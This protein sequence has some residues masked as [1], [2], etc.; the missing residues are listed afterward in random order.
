M[1]YSLKEHRISC[2]AMITTLHHVVD[3]FPGKRISARRSIYTDLDKKVIYDFYRQFSNH[4]KRSGVSVRV[5]LFVP[6]QR[7][8]CM[9]N[10]DAVV[11]LESGRSFQDVVES[12]A[13]EFMTACAMHVSSNALKALKRVIYHKVFFLSPNDFI[14]EQ[15]V[16]MEDEFSQQV[17]AVQTQMTK[18]SL[19]SVDSKIL[20]ELDESGVRHCSAMTLKLTSDSKL[21]RDEPVEV[22][23]RMVRSTRSLWVDDHD[24]MSVRAMFDS[25]LDFCKNAS[26]K[27]VITLVVSNAVLFTLSQIWEHGSKNKGFISVKLLIRQSEMWRVQ[28]QRKRNKKQY[29]SQVVQLDNDVVFDGGAAQVDGVGQ[30]EHQLDVAVSD[31]QNCDGNDDDYDQH[32]GNDKKKKV[33]FNSRLIQFKRKN[34]EAQAEGDSSKRIKNN[35][36]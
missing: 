28:Q 4:K 9:Q 16:A 11:D 21:L 27:T 15:Y 23:R 33:R 3:L 30:T 34:L 1:Y 8:F 35:L 18:Q 22:K 25:M 2:F 20:Q 24:W 32:K 7:Q 17:G 19:F 6:N 29:S 36:I 13:K 14:F 12:S 10:M 5:Q 26:I 31:A